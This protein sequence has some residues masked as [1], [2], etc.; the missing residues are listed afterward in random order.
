M[1]KLASPA[2]AAVVAVLKAE[3]VGNRFSAPGAE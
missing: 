1:W 3:H 2:A